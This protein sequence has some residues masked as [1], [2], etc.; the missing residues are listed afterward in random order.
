MFDT[1]VEPLIS[2]VPLEEDADETIIVN[3][4]QGNPTV[5]FVLQL[6][7]GQEFVVNGPSL[8]GRN[9]KPQ[10]G[11]IVEHTCVV[12][13]P[14][15]SVSKTHLELGVEGD[16]LW[17]RDLHSGN[18]TRVREGGAKETEIKPDTRVFVGLRTRVEIGNEFFIVLAG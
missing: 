6:S 9:P 1:P 2:E 18:G 16:R 13:D 15:R 17:I 12:L 10:P 3:N 8:L 14:A 7:T 4:R 11:Q 5:S